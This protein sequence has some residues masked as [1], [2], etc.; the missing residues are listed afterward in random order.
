MDRNFNHLPHNIIER[1]NNNE[2]SDSNI[3]NNINDQDNDEK[4]K[5]AIAEWA[6]SFNIPHNAC[7]ALLKILRKHTSCN[8][9]KDTRTL[10]QTPRQNNIIKICGGEFFYLSL[11]DIKKMLLKSNVKHIDLLVNIDGLPLA[12]SSHAALWPILCSNTKD[13][14][15]YLAGAYFGYKKPENFNIYLQPLVDDLN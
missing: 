3:V 1:E 2:F 15:V 8:F 11:N 13:N 7:N 14:A 4:F 12:K 6:V 10:L 9:S 5:N